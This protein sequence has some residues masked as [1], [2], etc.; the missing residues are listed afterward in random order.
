MFHRVSQGSAQG[1]TVEIF[2]V[3]FFEKIN[4]YLSKANSVNYETF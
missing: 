1:I 2:M 3:S 4:K